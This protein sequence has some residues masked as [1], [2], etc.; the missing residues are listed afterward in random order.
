MLPVFLYWWIYTHTHVA[1]AVFFH[2]GLRIHPIVV[3]Y[4]ECMVSHY[5]ELGS[6]AIRFSLLSLSAVGWEKKSR[7]GGRERE[8]ER[9]R[10]IL[11][12]IHV[13]VLPSLK[14]YSSVE[15]I[16][17]CSRV[18]YYCKGVHTTLRYM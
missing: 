1:K 14:A 3:Q 15:D 11:H 18:L 6:S 17:T 7:E 4:E 16:K 13:H 12:S 9:E 2:S 5:R 10:P 8:R